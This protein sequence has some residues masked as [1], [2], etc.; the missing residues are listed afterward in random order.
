MSV[1]LAAAHKQTTE[2]SPYW[3]VGLPHKAR[4]TFADST[5]GG[6]ASRGGTTAEGAGPRMVCLNS[7]SPSESTSLNCKF[8]GVKE[9]K[10]LP[11]SNIPVDFCFCFFF[12]GDS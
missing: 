9:R 2:E 4:V 6:S 8:W 10:Y 12:T 11:Y 5:G 1:L 3:S 7:S